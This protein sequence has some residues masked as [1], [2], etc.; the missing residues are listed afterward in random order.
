MTV[1]VSTLG[2]DLLVLHDTRG[3]SLLMRRDARRRYVRIVT[4]GFPRL[5]L[6]SFSFESRRHDTG[7][8][9]SDFVLERISKLT[10]VK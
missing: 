3:L 6:A 2:V 10:D 7:H 9:F 8:R 5:L 1:Y 4:H